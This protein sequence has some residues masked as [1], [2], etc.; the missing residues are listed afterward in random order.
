MWQLALAMA[1]VSAT[2]EGMYGAT[3]FGPAITFNVGWQVCF[4]LGISDGSLTNM[5]AALTVCE[6]ASASMQVVWLWRH[7]DWWLVVA[8]SAP[9]C[10]FLAAG[11]LLMIEVEKVRDG[12]AWLKRSIGILLLL[13]ALQRAWAVRSARRACKRA[14]DS[15]V[16]LPADRPPDAASVDAPPNGPPARGRGLDLH[17]TSMLSSIF[18]WFSFA[19]AMGGLTSI[20]GPPMMLFV[21]I[22]AQQIDMPVWRGSNAVM[23]LVLNIA[24][25]A[26]FAYKRV[27]P[28]PWPVALSM[29]GGGWLGLLVGNRAAHRFGDARSLD[30]FMI[31]FIL[32]AAALM[33][34]AGFGP[35]AE[36]PVS[37]AV[38]GVAALT[39]LGLGC[40][41]LRRSWRGAS[42]S[43]AQAAGGEIGRDA[44]LGPSAGDGVTNSRCIRDHQSAGD[45]GA[46]GRART[47]LLPGCRTDE[48]AARGA[49]AP[50]PATL[51][52]HVL[53]QPL[54]SQ[55]RDC[56]YFLLELLDPQASHLAKHPIL[57]PRAEAADSHS[58]RGRLLLGCRQRRR[59]VR[60]RRRVLLGT[61]GL[62]RRVAALGSLGAR[63]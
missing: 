27:P 48:G 17:S 44:L 35:A 52:C 55:A 45:D 16:D 26:V 57:T 8:M 3:T 20:S 62:R 54:A 36:R 39:A 24:R 40:A 47:R 12:S 46:R 43:G 10:G 33:E 38:G 34:G 32:Y 41:Q 15:S 61:T 23:R 1:L 37:V 60:R 50:Q 63:C 11:Q 5:A 49:I 28:S 6:I 56:S 14:G 9:C 51:L 19:G 7:I 18:F 29:V 53:R 58:G 59:S 2:S 31:T 21:S 30:F 13:M 25:A 42:R 4:L 22:H